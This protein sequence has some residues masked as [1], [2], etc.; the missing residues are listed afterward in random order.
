MKST[1]LRT[2]ATRHLE[3]WDG[4]WMGG[5]EATRQAYTSYWLL[6]FF[7]TSKNEMALTTIVKYVVK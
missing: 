5:V 2:R 3:Q 1:K 4:P 7:I 6:L